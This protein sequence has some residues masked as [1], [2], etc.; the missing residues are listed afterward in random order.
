MTISERV[1][2]RLKELSMSQVR[3]SE[4]TG[5]RQSTISEWKKKNS[6]PTSD[7]I[8]IICQTLNVTPEWLLSGVDGA[9][10]RGKKQDYYVVEKESD[11]GGLICDY[12][13][14]NGLNQG[15]L[16]GYARALV[17]LTKELQDGEM[18]LEIQKVNK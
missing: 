12:N 5:I 15:R 7:K 13:Q 3:F 11:L 2:S 10:S 18:P 17:H 9:A 14:L 4:K 8:M 16:L 1:F 6:N